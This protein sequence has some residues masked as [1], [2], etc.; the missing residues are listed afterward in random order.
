M[1]LSQIQSVLGGQIQLVTSGSAPISA[2][3]MDFLKV[4]FA[5]EVDEGT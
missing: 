4:A 3:V 5:C 1:N 2:E